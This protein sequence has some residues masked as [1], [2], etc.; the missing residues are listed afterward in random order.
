VQVADVT[1]DPRTG[2]YARAYLAVGLRGFLTV[3]VLRRG[4]LVACVMVG[5]DAPRQWSRE[6]VRL[7]EEVA[8][9]S[10]SAVERE[11]AEASLAASEERLALALEG[12]SDGI[13]DWNLRTGAVF[14]SARFA[15][16]LGH[17][18][19][20]WESTYA[21]LIARMHPDDVAPTETLLRAYI[22]GDVVE[23]APVF[24]M[25]HRDGTWRWIMSRARMVRD[26][27]GTVVRMVGAHTDVTDRRTAEEALRELNATLEARVQ[28]V[29]SERSRLWAVSDD[30]FVTAGSTGSCTRS[31]TVGPMSWATIGPRCSLDVELIHP[32]DL[33]AVL[34]RLDELRTTGWTAT[35]DNR[36][37][38]ADGSWRTISWRLAIE[39]GGDRL[40]GVGRDVTAEREQARALAETQRQLFEVQ[41]METIGRLTGGVAHDF[42]N[43][44]SVVLSNLD[45]IH[46]R[47]TDP[48][49]LR[50]VEG[51]IMGAERGATL[52]RRLLAVARRQD[53]KAE[54]VAI[55]VLFRGMRVLLE[56]S[57][58]PASR[59][60]KSFQPISR[61]SM[62]I[63]TSSNSR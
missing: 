18:P 49:V 51:A 60:R 53:L 20:E 10:W 4:R 62:S 56:R 28:A 31:A 3:P 47:V 17:E 30:L 41:K 44:L 21:N 29:P 39:P 19:H 24:R 14:H 45:L 15:A 58:G 43:L 54:T 59:S 61:R 55:P 5:D 50:L 16:Q 25:R 37:R 42:N 38:C 40:Y 8:E 35:Y 22:A 27:A 9:R 48:R 57:L 12:T 2:P 52:T 26:A 1:T 23:Y 63:P 6:D 7:L 36:V 34:V 32:D 13:W 46:K 33:P 11:R